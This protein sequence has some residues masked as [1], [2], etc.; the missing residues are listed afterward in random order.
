MKLVVDM[1]LSPAWVTFLTSENIEAVHWST[2][3]DPTAPDR[4]IFDYARENGLII[5]TSDLDFSAILAATSL[6][7]PSVTQL[8]A[9]D[10]RL[11]ATGD[12]VVA[13]LRLFEAELA[14]GA[15]LTVDLFQARLRLLP[16]TRNT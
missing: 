15:I 10:L 8:R 14:Q 3:G 5:L 9:P 12:K 16:L 4:E 7:K 1:N 6:P 11:S 13:A 2:I